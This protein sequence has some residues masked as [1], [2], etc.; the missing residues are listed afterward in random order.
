MFSVCS[1]LI[2]FRQELYTASQRTIARRG[3]FI[4]GES[5]GRVKFEVSVDFEIGIAVE[6]NKRMYAA[7]DLLAA[8][9]RSSRSSKGQERSIGSVL[10]GFFVDVCWWKLAAGG[11][12]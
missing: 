1:M 8:R 7:A 10:I 4:W 5:F 3:L 11:V 6:L 12:C 2:A 9:K